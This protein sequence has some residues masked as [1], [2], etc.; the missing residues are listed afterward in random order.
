[1]NPPHSVIH[2]TVL[3]LPHGKIQHVFTSAIQIKHGYQPTLNTC[4]DKQ[5]TI[6]DETEV[7]NRRTD[8]CQEMLN[9]NGDNVNT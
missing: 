9:K 6:V 3:S 7:M 1:M 5:G 2:H 8:N 4:T